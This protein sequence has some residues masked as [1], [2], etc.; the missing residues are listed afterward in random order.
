[1]SQDI[2]ASD[3]SYAFGNNQDLQ[4]QQM[5]GQEM[6]ETEGAGWQTTLAKF[7]WRFAQQTGKTV[8]GAYT[9]CISNKV[10]CANVSSIPLTIL[11]LFN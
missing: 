6:I 3:L 4:M 11:N 2:Q 9:W 8:Q 5:T 10:E 1:M 7:L